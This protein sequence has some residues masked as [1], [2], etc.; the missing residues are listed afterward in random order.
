MGAT[1]RTSSGELLWFMNIADFERSSPHFRP[2]VL[3]GAAGGVGV[4][5][6]SAIADATTKAR[7]L[8]A[9]VNSLSRPMLGGIVFVTP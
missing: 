4:A 6:N 7:R 8:A 5:I 1:A 9:V 2:P 3:S